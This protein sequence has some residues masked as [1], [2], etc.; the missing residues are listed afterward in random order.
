MSYRTSALWGRCPALTPLLQLSLQAGHRVPLTMCNPW[1][2]CSALLSL[3]LLLKYPSDLVQHCSCPPARDWG[4]RVSGLVF[5]SRV[6]A[7]LVSG[8]YSCHSRGPQQ[9][10]SYNFWCPRAVA[11]FFFLFLCASGPLAIVNDPH[12]FIIDI[13][14]YL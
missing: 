13:P 1:M 8:R 11:L 4:S 9:F 2:T 5:L 10:A 3:L 7:P 6:H 12:S 14:V